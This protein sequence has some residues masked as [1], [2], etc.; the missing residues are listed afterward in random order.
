MLSQ[1]PEGDGPSTLRAFSFTMD[2]LEAVSKETSSLLKRRQAS[3]RAVMEAAKKGEEEL[4]RVMEERF[5][6]L[7]DA[8]F[9]VFLNSEID[10]QASNPAME[11]F[12][13]TIKLRILEEVGR[14]RGIDI[15][16]LPK[17]AA[18]ENLQTMRAKTLQYIA[19]FDE[20]GKLLFLQT[21]G[22]VRRELEKRYANVSFRPSQFSILCLSCWIILVHTC[23]INIY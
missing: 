13:V 3:L 8:E 7:S 10:N 2:F 14:S 21:L 6:E 11:S 20:E 16:I 22:I 5:S 15:A 4:N 17:L 9:L 12:L 19:G 1:I 18:E 23:F